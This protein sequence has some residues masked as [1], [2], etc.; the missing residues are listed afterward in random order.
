MEKAWVYGE[1]CTTTILHRVQAMYS[2]IVLSP[3]ERNRL[4]DCYRHGSNRHLRLRAHIILLLAQ[5]RSYRTIAAVLFCSSRTIR[6][7]SQRFLEQ[8]VEGLLGRPV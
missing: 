6:C 8:R 5:G 1:W 7:W 2:S 3:Q 4:L